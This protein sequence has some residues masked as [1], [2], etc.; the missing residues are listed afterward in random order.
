M[1][2]RGKSPSCDAPDEISLLFKASNT[3][4]DPD[5]PTTSACGVTRR[6]SNPSFVDPVVL[7]DPDD[8]VLP[9]WESML[10]LSASDGLDNCSQVHEFWY[11][12]WY[13][14]YELAECDRDIWVHR[15]C[16]VEFCDFDREEINKDYL[17]A[18]TLAQKR[19]LMWM[20]R[21]AAT[22][23]FGGACFVIRNI[24]SNVKRQKSVYYHLL[25]GM[26]IFD[27]ITAVAWVFA[28]API[29][30]DIDHVCAT[31]G[32]STDATCKAQAFLVHLGFTSIFYNVSL[33]FYYVMVVAYLYNRKE[34]KL[35]AIQHYLHGFPLLIGLGL[36][37]GALPT[38]HWMDYGCHILPYSPKYDEGKLWS[39]LVFVVL[40]LGFSIASIS[41]AMLI[42]YWKVS[43]QTS[44][45]KKWQLGKGSINKLESQVFWQCLFYVLAFYITWPIL[46]SAYLASVDVDGPLGLTLTVAFV[47]PLQGFDNFLVFVRPKL[48]RM[49]RD[50]WSRLRRTQDPA[51][52]TMS[53]NTDRCVSSIR[54]QD[55]HHE[56]T[57]RRQSEVEGSPPAP[58]IE[59]LEELSN[60][61]SCVVHFPDGTSQALEHVDDMDPS[62]LLP[63]T[64]DSTRESHCPPRTCTPKFES[65]KEE[66]AVE[67]PIRSPP[68]F[69]ESL[70]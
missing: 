7:A 40:P 16:R 55:S 59:G 29:S 19:A 27:I 42:V 60:H 8:Y 48:L 69:Q 45:A 26:E 5:K 39:M 24:F 57:P 22:F 28:T 43:R 37:F 4:Y 46:F 18:T 64:K 20:S 56:S 47:A 6:S 38:Y 33:A 61:E 52:G 70:A 3:F 15:Q 58:V 31:S 44:Q 62:A 2:Q 23:S 21:A 12:S 50:R 68:K 54:A 13:L 30:K 36:A 51:G 25:F 67:L 35:K 41:A 1:L 17:G 63:L 11:D 49:A 53:S 66:A 34:F 32:T 14:P 65:I 10:N 9:S